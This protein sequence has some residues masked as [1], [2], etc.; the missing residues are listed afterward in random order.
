[1]KI[2]RPYRLVLFRPD[3]NM[4]QMRQSHD[5]VAIGVIIHARG[6]NIA[7]RARRRTLA[8]G[9]VPLSRETRERQ[10]RR[11]DETS[12]L[13]KHNRISSSRPDLLA[14]AEGSG[15]RVPYMRA[16]R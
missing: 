4:A 3:K 15:F 16:A 7:R 1:M 6:R 11:R 13:I 2:I 12:A 8:A 5:G 9:Q 10:R 14:R